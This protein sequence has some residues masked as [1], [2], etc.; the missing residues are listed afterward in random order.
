MGSYIDQESLF[1]LSNDLIRV[2]TEDTE[3][4]IN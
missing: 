3:D 4:V 1:E 2:F